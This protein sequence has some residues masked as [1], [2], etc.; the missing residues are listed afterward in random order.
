MQIPK[1]NQESLEKTYGKD[2][3][4]EHSKNIDCYDLLAKYLK[5]RVT[6]I[7]D[8]GCGHGLLVDCL[9]KNGVDAYGLEGS[10]S[11]KEMWSVENINRFKIIDFTKSDKDIFNTEYV[12]TTEV[13]EHLPPE[14]A[15]SFVQLLVQNQP[16]NVFF[17][18]ATFF[19]D[20][21]KNQSHVNEQPIGYWV[22]IF[23]K[24]GYDI[25]IVECY[26]LKKFFTENIKQFIKCWWYPKNMIV[27]TKKENININEIKKIDHINLQPRTFEACGNNVILYIIFYRDFLEYSN[28]ILMKYLEYTKENDSTSFS[29]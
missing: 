21:G 17:G 14:S 26:N 20:I 12:I 23:N 16:K 4:L 9:I 27:L 19:Q 24:Y 15:E 2:F 25:D 28:L 5:T 13:A 6:S 3:F 1:S 11:A 22:N 10:V 29:L 7:T 18:A 8:Y